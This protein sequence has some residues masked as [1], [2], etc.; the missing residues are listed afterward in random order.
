[1]TAKL[2]K[3]R[4]SIKND[5][6]QLNKVRAYNTRLTSPH[7]IE[8]RVASQESEKSCICVLEASILL[9]F[10]IFFSDFENLATVWYFDFCLTFHYNDHLTTCRVLW[11][12]QGK[13]ESDRINH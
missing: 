8:V 1:M 3:Q 4:Y 11:R 5:L 13:K 2:I 12:V 6:T 10:A 7:N 9:L